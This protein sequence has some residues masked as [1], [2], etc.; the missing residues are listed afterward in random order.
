MRQGITTV[1]LCSS[2]MSQIDRLALPLVTSK[3]EVTSGRATYLFEMFEFKGYYYS[4][5]PNSKLRAPIDR[6]PC[7]ILPGHSPVEEAR[8]RLAGPASRRARGVLDLR[9]QPLRLRTQL[10]YWG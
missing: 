9:E 6:S 2:W 4:N 3:F 5:T 10:F 8:S 1:Y 7:L